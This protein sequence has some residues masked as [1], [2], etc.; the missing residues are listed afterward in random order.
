MATKE[1]TQRAKAA[2]LE[3]DNRWS[4]ETTEEKIVQAEQERDQEG[5]ADFKPQAEVP[6]VEVELIRDRWDQDGKREKRGK[7]VSL[8]V[9]DAMR[10]VREGKARE[11]EDAEEANS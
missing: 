2:G 4:D 3:I 5:R 9:K 6:L 10:A 7:R 8:P 1:Q 11:V